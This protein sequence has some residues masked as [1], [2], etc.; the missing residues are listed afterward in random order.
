VVLDDGDVFLDDLGNLLERKVIVLSNQVER[1]K[2]KDGY[3]KD[4]GK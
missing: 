2:R 1:R 4:E 3:P